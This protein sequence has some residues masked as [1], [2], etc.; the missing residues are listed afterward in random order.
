MESWHH[1]VESS[2]MVLEK[3]LS[4]IPSRHSLAIALVTVQWCNWF[5]FPVPLAR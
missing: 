4:M 3:L 5:F 1:T 2:E